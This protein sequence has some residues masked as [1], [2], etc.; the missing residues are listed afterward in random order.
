MHG[1][2]G[3]RPFRRSGVPARSLSPRQWLSGA[4]DRG[5]HG[6][7]QNRA[8][9]C[10]HSASTAAAGEA[11]PGIRKP[12]S[13]C[14][15]G[16]FSGCG[17]PQPTLSTFRSQ[18]VDQQKIIRQQQVT[19]RAVPRVS[20]LAFQISVR[21]SGRKPTFRS[22][23]NLLRASS[24]TADA[25]FSSAEASAP[26]T[27]SGSTLGR[28]SRDRKG[29]VRS[30]RIACIVHDRPAVSDHSRPDMRLR[31]RRR[32]TAPFLR[33]SAVIA[34]RL[35]SSLRFRRSSRTIPAWRSAGS[36]GSRTA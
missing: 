8:P 24:A 22:G 15:E 19:R 3:W 30:P 18:T 14:L 25:E 2:P 26:I 31:T 11:S 7:A 9:S 35:T 16:L 33:S 28:S 36:W 29:D 10:F 20:L 6:L 34:S 4:V 21:S 27:T 12:S 1:A 32:T 13:C 23:P 17:G 5:T